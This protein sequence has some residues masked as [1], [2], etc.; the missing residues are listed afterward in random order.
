MCG[1]TKIVSSM[2]PLILIMRSIVQ[3]GLGKKCRRIRIEISI[4]KY[5]KDKESNVI[6]WISERL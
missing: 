5:L 3:Q 4:S 2:Q 1:S 6:S